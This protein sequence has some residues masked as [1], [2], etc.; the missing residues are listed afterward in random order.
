MCEYKMPRV[1]QLP[2]RS[3]VRTVC[4]CQWVVYI[5]VLLRAWRMRIT[6]LFGRLNVTGMKEYT[7]SLMTH[8]AA[9]NILSLLIGQEIS[10]G[11]SYW[12]VSEGNINIL[13]T[14]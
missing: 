6:L 4:S 9:E 11:A 12:S 14:V 3:H 8:L 2:G 5:V 10:T 1:C 13:L 7:M